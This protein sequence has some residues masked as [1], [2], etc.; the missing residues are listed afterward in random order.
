MIR[1]LPICETP[2]KAFSFLTMEGLISFAGRG[3]NDWMKDVS[4]TTYLYSRMLRTPVILSLFGFA[5]WFFFAG[6]LFLKAVPLTSELN[7]HSTRNKHTIRSKRCSP[8]L[9]CQ[10]RASRS[11]C[12]CSGQQWFTCIWQHFW[13]EQ[14]RAPASSDT[15]CGLT[16]NSW[17]K[18]NV[19]H[20]TI[21][22]SAQ[23]AVHCAR[24]R[25]SL[26]LTLTWGY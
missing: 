4:K 11:A 2:S 18:S 20:V 3:K 26:E 13:A 8:R 10:T 19:W 12:T 16:G 17:K 7:W 22:R 21:S 23:D 15:F 1:T 9:D 6:P 25:V 5:C 24:F 14:Q